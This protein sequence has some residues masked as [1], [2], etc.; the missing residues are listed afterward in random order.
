MISGPCVVRPS[1]FVVQLREVGEQ[2]FI[3]V[4]LYTPAVAAWVATT[5]SVLLGRKVDW[6][7]KK[8]ATG[9]LKLQASSLVVES[10]G[11]EVIGLLRLLQSALI[12]S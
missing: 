12:L 8:M 3:Q 10:V 11:L 9:E 2:R 4:L 1:E 7:C 5:S 6:H